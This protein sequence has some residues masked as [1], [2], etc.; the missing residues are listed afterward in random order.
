MINKDSWNV[1][2]FEYNSDLDLAMTSATPCFFIGLSNF[3]LIELALAHLAKASGFVLL[4]C[5][6][7]IGRSMCL[8]LS[9][10]D[11]LRDFVSIPSIMQ[12]F[13]IV[14][15]DKLFSLSNNLRLLP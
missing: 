2:F 11:C 12:R 8:S 3:I 7:P 4:Q 5:L 9:N 13:L 14:S 15:L 1:G 10:I 6:S